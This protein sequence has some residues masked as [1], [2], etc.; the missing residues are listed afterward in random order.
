M[1]C[2]ALGA[3]PMLGAVSVSLPCDD[4]RGCARARRPLWLALACVRLRGGAG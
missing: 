1:G 3:N 4:E 2:R